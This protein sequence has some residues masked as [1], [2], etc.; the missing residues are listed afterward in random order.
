MASAPLQEGQLGQT[1]ARIFYRYVLFILLGCLGLG[2]GIAL[3][4]TA[5]LS[6]QIVESQALQQAQATIRMVQEAERLYQE[7]K[8]KQPSAQ[9][10]ALTGVTQLAPESASLNYWTLLSQRLQGQSD[11]MLRVYDLST[12]LPSDPFV[13]EAQA[14]LKKQPQQVYHRKDRIGGQR[15]L[16]YAAAIPTAAGSPQLIEIGQSIEQSAQATQTRLWLMGLS[17]TGVSSLILSCIT[18]M[19][20]GLRQ[21]NR[22][23]KLQLQEQTQEQSKLAT[24]DELTQLATCRQFQK[25][26]DEEW[27]RMQ[28]RTQD[29]SLIVCRIDFFDEFKKAYGQ[30]ASE[31]CLRVVAR[32][33]QSNVHRV[34]DV[35]ARYDEASFAILLPHTNEVQ[36]VQIVA[37]VADSVHGLKIE[38]SPS[39]VNARVTLSLGVAT[40]IPNSHRQP[41]ELLDM[42]YSALESAQEKGH[43]CFVVNTPSSTQA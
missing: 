16:R 18:F 40:L 26:L 4:G 9:E 17:L 42:A 12:A 14:Y 25:A 15:Y 34:G 28:R 41:Q 39:P 11:S 43:N 36:A 23:L 20:R 3:L 31:V 24:V 19:L 21:H 22:N 6:N 5:Q 37:K 7:A 30:P 38:H 27:R 35:S 1:L 32:A 10:A 29:L 8:T 2:G 13:Q 33:I